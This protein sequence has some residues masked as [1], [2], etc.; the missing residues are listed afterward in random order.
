M[1]MEGINI[2]FCHIFLG[3]F[4]INILAQYSARDIFR[5]NIQAKYS[6]HQV[7]I[8]LHIYGEI[9]GVNIH[10]HVFRVIAGHL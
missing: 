5:L 7:D 1:I 6:W 8:S 3:I 2:F 9:F 10:V 4:G